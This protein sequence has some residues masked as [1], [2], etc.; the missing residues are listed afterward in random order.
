MVDLRLRESSLLAPSSCRVSSRDSRNLWS[1]YGPALCFMFKG[2]RIESI[3]R[4]QIRIR[5]SLL[6]G[7]SGSTNGIDD[8][9]DEE[10][11]AGADGRSA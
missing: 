9:E 8:D 1:T 5:S 6:G 11:G 3:Y 10:P 7:A 2:Q 4:V